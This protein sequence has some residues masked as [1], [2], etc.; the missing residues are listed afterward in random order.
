MDPAGLESR[1]NQILNLVRKVIKV[2]E[3]NVE[4]DSNDY[5]LISC[6][7]ALQDLSHTIN[8]EVQFAIDAYDET[9]KRNAA[10]KN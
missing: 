7:G 10:K 8:K 5:E 4:K 2:I 3:D 6:R 1:G 9:T